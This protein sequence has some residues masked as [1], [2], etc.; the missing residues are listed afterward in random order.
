MQYPKCCNCHSL[1]LFVF[2]TNGL[3][4]YLYCPMS[5]WKKRE[6]RDILAL[7]MSTSKKATLHLTLPLFQQE[8]GLLLGS[9]ADKYLA[10]MSEEEMIIYDRLINLPSNDWEI[11]YWTTGAKPTPDEFDNE[12]MDK[13]KEHA[14]NKDKEARITM[15][16]L[17]S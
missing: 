3:L 6:K 4:S 1:S 12:V 11:F 8:M 16:P 13:L 17:K 10:E 9:F 15:P 5:L 2:T 7:K 14:K